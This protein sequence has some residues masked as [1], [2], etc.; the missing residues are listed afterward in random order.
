MASKN[1]HT[2]IVEILLKDKR[3]DP[4]AGDNRAIVDACV[5]GTLRLLHCF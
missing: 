5:Y 4:G 3:V 2:D 1:G